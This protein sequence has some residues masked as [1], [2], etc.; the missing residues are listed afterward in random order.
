MSGLDKKSILK[1]ISA[2]KNDAIFKSLILLL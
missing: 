2:L 1:F